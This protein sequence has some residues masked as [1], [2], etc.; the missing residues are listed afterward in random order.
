MYARII[1][2]I[3]NKNEN[4]G[5][6]KSRKHMRTRLGGTQNQFHITLHKY[7]HHYKQNTKRCTYVGF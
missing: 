7:L 3:F 1:K 2:N 4:V 6:S 5:M